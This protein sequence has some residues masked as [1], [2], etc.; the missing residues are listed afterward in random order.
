MGMG[1]PNNHRSTPATESTDALV[2]FR[3]GDLAG[4]DVPDLPGVDDAH[5][6]GGFGLDRLGEDI[7]QIFGS[8][9]T[10]EHHP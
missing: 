7:G 10:L 2:C 3:R 4:E 9:F 1:I 6:H 8:G 5:Q